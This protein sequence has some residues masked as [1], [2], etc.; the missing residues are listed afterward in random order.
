MTLAENHFLIVA[1]VAVM[2]AAP[3][4]AAA[5][6]MAGISRSSP[7]TPAAVA[8]GLAFLA[9]NGLAWLWHTG[10]GVACEFGDRLGGGSFI[11][12]DGITTV[13]LPFVALVMLANLLV[14][15]KRF[16]D[17]P[18]TAR[19]LGSA[20]G[21]FALFATAHPI[22]IVMLWIATALPAWVATRG[23]PGGRPA[24][25][26]FALALLAALG[27]VAVGTMLMLIDPPWEK[28]CGLVGTTGGWL[29]AVAVLFRE[30]IVP[31]HSWYPAVY[32]AAPLS[33]ALAATVP[34]VGAYTAVRL[35]IGHADHGAGV[36]QELVVVSQLA[37]V[38][39]VYGGALAV[40]QR[41]LRGLI[42][43]LAMSQSAM[44]LAALAG[45]LPM[46]LNGAFCVWI[47]SGLSLTG[48][49]LV[50]WALESRA[51]PLS[52]ETPQGRFRDSPTLAA[53]FMLFGLASIGLPGTLSFVADDLIV[54]GS[55]DEQ[56][57]AGLMV[58]AS[59]VLAAIAVLRGWFTIFGGPSAI[60]GPRHR[61]L[62]RERVAL[63][64]LLVPIFVFG[65]FPAPLVGAL[66]RAAAELLGVPVD[67]APAG[68]E[69]TIGPP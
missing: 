35:L 64:A 27:C 63:L 59:T 12:V 26:V 48:I 44:V 43:M 45:K 57:H 50:A 13:L 8:L 10:D 37:L 52:L 47:S 23:T 7:R 61:I 16:L 67:H 5:A 29:V 15:P 40:V 6:V 53:L 42:G 51:G 68:G 60:D 38:T 36:A 46:E 31:F 19:I 21:T 20:S 65:L 2:V 1:L 9:A 17:V 25:R 34:Q 3:L 66:E 11:H 49:A 24:A 41:D 28:N 56:L 62:L 22:L 58:I 55:L 4:L 54:S 32:S 14:A 18:A 39:A 69:V 30:G 33:M